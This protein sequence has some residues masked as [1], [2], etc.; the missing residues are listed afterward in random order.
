M[1]ASRRNYASYAQALNAALHGS[2]GEFAT[3][4]NFGET[5]DAEF[6]A[7][8]R[9]ILQ[10]AD[11][12][13]TAFDLVEDDDAGGVEDAGRVVGGWN[14]V[15]IRDELFRIPSLPSFG[16]VFRR[17]LAL[18]VGGFHP[19]LGARAVA[20]LCRRMARAGATMACIPLKAGRKR[21]RLPSG[22]PVVQTADGPA[23]SPAGHDYFLSIAANLRIEVPIAVNEFFS[24]VAPRPL[25]VTRDD[26]PSW[27]AVK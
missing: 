6:L 23:R 20:D 9:P 26:L 19:L 17:E 21:V 5:L 12:V 24:R 8:L 2:P 10:Q 15:A 18:R 13:L 4:V 14:P 7:R 27:Q 22:N 16:L 25:A 3:C 11:V 1:I